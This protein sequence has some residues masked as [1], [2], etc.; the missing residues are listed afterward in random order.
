MT[1]RFSKPKSQHHLTL[2]TQKCIITWVS[3]S[4][5][6]LF[7]SSPF[8]SLKEK[9]LSSSTQTPKNLKLPTLA[10]GCKV[11][12]CP[13]TSV[14]L[15]AIAC[16]AC[17]GAKSTCAMAFNDPGLGD[18]TK[19]QLA[20][21]KTGVEKSGIEMDVLLLLRKHPFWVIGKA[22]ISSLKRISFLAVISCKKTNPKMAKIDWTLFS[23]TF[24]KKLCF[25]TLWYIKVA[26]PQLL[27]CRSH[28]RDAWLTAA[29]GS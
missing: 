6:P 4:H 21:T 13:K 14:F 1:H 26:K 9:K 15:S 22:P 24:G 28:P 25:T 27:Q 17:S 16:F 12:N 19:L 3:C 18:S 20:T 5:L 23:K 7:Q 8:F 11:A 29:E 10:S 2:K